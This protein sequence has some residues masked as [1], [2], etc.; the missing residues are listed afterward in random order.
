M[1]EGRRAQTFHGPCRYLWLPWFA[2]PMSML[3]GTPA[4]S[5]CPSKPPSLQG[6]ERGSAQLAV[7]FGMQIA[8]TRNL[9][10]LMPAK[11]NT[12]PDLPQQLGPRL[13]LASSQRMLLQ[14]LQN[15][16]KARDFPGVCCCSRG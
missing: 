8:V 2:Q 9:P 13:G 12:C 5:L 3:L 4:L 10:K 11:G 7:F 15:T 1:Q 14:C 16:Q 6:P